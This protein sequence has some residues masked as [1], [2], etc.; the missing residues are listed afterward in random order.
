M[1][2]LSGQEYRGRTIAFGR[3]PRRCFQMAGATRSV[4]QCGGVPEDIDFVSW[5]GVLLNYSCRLVSR[6][7]RC[8]QSIH[9]YNVLSVVAQGEPCCDASRQQTP[10]LTSVNSWL[11]QLFISYIIVSCDLFVAI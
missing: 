6:P 10:G 2:V 3:L 8:A 9:Y 5:D 7:R 4:R 11:T 1:D